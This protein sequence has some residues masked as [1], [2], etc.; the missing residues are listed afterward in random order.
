MGVLY[1]AVTAK[2]KKCAST[3]AWALSAMQRRQPGQR[4]ACLRLLELRLQQPLGVLRKK[5]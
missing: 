2:N 4:R 1:T 5:F 3:A